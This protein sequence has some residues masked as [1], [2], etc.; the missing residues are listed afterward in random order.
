LNLILRKTF[1]EMG[2]HLK[3]LIPVHNTFHRVIPGQSSTPIGHIDLKVSCGIGE[4]K[5]K[6]TLTFEMASFDIGY[7]CILERPFLLK[8]IAV[9]HTAYT[10]MKIPR[11]KG[12][13]TIKSNQCDTLACENATLTHDGRFGEKVAQEQAAKVAKT[14]GGSAPLKSLTP[15]PSTIGTPRPPPAKKG[16][17]VA[18]GSG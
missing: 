6:E 4:N 1:I 18:S 14:F 8:F 10:T 16:T 13:I 3:D 12:V 5:W 17:H 2:L 15:K 7:N 11:P 9:I